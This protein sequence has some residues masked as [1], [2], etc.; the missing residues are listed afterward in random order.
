MTTSTW[1]KSGDA[2]VTSLDLT[3]T[4]NN[5]TFRLSSFTVTYTD[6]QWN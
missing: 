6:Y 3:F 5:T 4:R 1:A 2:P